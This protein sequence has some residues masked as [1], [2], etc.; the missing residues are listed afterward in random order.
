MEYLDEHG[1]LVTESLRDFTKNALKKHF[2]SLDE[3]LKRWKSAE[4]KQ[5]MI[6]ELENEGL[7][8]IRLPRKSARTSIL[9]TLS[10]TW[11][12]TSRH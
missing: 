10:A 6:E 4:R 12:S 9:S 11:H 1:K 7:S 3:F 8:L 5:A 2:A